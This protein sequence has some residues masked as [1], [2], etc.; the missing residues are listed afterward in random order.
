MALYWNEY[1]RVPALHAYMELKKQADLDKTW[2]TWREKALARLRED[3]EARHNAGERRELAHGWRDGDR[4]NGDR[5]RLVEILLWERNPE[6]AWQEAVKGRCSE[7]LWMKLA[8]ERE[9]KHPAD[10]IPLWRRRVERLT[11]DANQSD[12][13]P[14]AES[15]KK[16]GALMEQTGQAEAFATLMAEIRLTRKTRRTFIAELDRKKLP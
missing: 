16:L 5:S 4:E 6:G 7:E 12:Y 15:L 11:R 10:C 1:E 3:I 13:A 2:P 8:K 9:K 14:A